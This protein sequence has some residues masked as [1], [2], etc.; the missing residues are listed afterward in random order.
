MMGNRVRCLKRKRSESERHQCCQ[1]SS[2]E[3]KKDLLQKSEFVHFFYYELP[4][5]DDD[6]IAK[7]GLERD[8][9]DSLTKGYFLLMKT[10]Y[11][12]FI[13]LSFHQQNTRRGFVQPGG[14]IRP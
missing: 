5:N 13:S 10:Q 2:F 9:A 6:G 8:T 11:S 7:I 12:L 14:L 3:W 1:G 4:H